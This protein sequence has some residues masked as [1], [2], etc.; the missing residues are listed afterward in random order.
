[1]R[2]YL[3]SITVLALVALPH[4]K[5]HSQTPPALEGVWKGTVSIVQ[6][7]TDI[8][9]KHVS[10][11]K[12]F[13]VKSDWV[14]DQT[15]FELYFSNLDNGSRLVQAQNWITGSFELPLNATEGDVVA[16]WVPSYGGGKIQGSIIPK[17]LKF[18][19]DQT[20]GKMTSLSLKFTGAENLSGGGQGLG[21]RITTGTVVL[22]RFGPKP[23]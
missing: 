8:K 21:T 16:F 22:K 19:V 15:H 4:Q 14:E 17:S 23:N 11:L 5:T 7:F 12:V 20:S 10:L 13:G 1:M 2:S 3:L 18:S 6:N 9:E